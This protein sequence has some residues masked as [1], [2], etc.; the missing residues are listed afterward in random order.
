MNLPLVRQESVRSS[1]ASFRNLTPSSGSSALSLL[2]SARTAAPADHLRGRAAE[3][4]APHGTRT[5][6]LRPSPRPQL[7]T[8][9]PAPPSQIQ[10]LAPPPVAAMLAGTV[11]AV[12]KGSEL[13]EVKAPIFDVVMKYFFTGNF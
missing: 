7:R 12:Q 11:A 10:G 3:G 5:A 13:A 2:P 9:G 1:T 6:A 8:G 4:T